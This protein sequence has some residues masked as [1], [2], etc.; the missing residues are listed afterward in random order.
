MKFVDLDYY[1]EDMSNKI[2]CIKVPAAKMRNP[3][4]LDAMMRKVDQFRDRREK[5]KSNPKNSNWEW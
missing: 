1:E 2:E 3:Y 4:A 5:R